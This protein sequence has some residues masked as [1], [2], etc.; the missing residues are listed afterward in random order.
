MDP[1][2]QNTGKHKAEDT[3]PDVAS[4]LV[5]ETVNLRNRWNYLEAWKLFMTTINDGE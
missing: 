3:L 2:N 1:H 5:Q 4:F